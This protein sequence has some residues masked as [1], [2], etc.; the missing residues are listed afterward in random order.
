MMYSSPPR[1][2]PPSVDVVDVPF[3]LCLFLSSSWSGC[4]LTGKIL[5]ARLGMC[6]SPHWSRIAHTCKVRLGMT[7]LGVLVKALGSI[8]NITN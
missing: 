3:L 6:C 2:L 5:K 8:P 7:Q 1:L 4:T